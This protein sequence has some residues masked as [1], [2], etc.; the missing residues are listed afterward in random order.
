[1]SKTGSQV[2]V[3][4][5]VF[6]EKECNSE[7][8]SEVISGMKCGFDHSNVKGYEVVNIIDCGSSEDFNSYNSEMK[9]ID[10]FGTPN[11]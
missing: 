8:I 10:V 3:M 7:H 11:D 5:K 4:L 2:L 9:T 1:M 6:L